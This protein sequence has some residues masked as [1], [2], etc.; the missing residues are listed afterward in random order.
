MRQQTIHPKIYLKSYQ[1]YTT[2]TFKNDQDKLAPP[3]SIDA[4]NRE[5]APHV[6]P[7]KI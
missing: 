7:K 6:P 5:G 4:H 2:R 3:P 1:K